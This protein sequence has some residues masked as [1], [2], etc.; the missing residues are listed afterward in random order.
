MKEREKI[1]PPFHSRLLKFSV[2]TF[3]LCWRLSEV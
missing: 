1:H 2:T 3:P